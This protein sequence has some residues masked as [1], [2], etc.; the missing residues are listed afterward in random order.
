M[1]KIVMNETIQSCYVLKDTMKISE[2]LNETQNNISNIT[3]QLQN[4]IIKLNRE[5]KIILSRA[6]RKSIPKKKGNRY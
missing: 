5:N 1:G 2:R 3:N 4:D 6:W